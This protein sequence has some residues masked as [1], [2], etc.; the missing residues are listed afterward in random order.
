MN[1]IVAIG[2]LI[3]PVA[4]HLLER[5]QTAALQKPVPT[6]ALYPSTAPSPPSPPSSP[7]H[8]PAKLSLLGTMAARVADCW[9]LL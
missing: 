4:T 2:R 3:A 5:T 7:P 9:D 1:I 6:S 8:S